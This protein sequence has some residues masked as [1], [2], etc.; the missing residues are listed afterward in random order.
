[1]L[2]KISPPISVSIATV[3]GVQ[4]HD[5]VMWAT[6][7]YTVLM[8][9]HKL[10]VMYTDYLEA[11]R[12]KL[13]RQK[14]VERRVSNTKLRVPELERRRTNLGPDTLPPAN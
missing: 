11:H 8:I 10:Y 2:A 7:I 5:L 6:L 13:W 12:L 9:C 3:F 1:M 4:V 14:Y